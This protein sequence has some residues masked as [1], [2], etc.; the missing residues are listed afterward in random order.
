MPP[1]RINGLTKGQGHTLLLRWADG[2]IMEVPAND[3]LQGVDLHKHIYRAAT[4]FTQQ[5]DTPH[6]LAV[7]FDARIKSVQEYQRGWQHI[8]FDHNRVENS[9]SSA[10]YSYVSDRGAEQRIAAPALLPWMD[11]LLSPWYDCVPRHASRT[12]AGLI[13]QLPLIFAL[14]AFSAPPKSLRVLLSS[15]QPGKWMH[16]NLP[17]GRK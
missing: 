2:R 3:P 16:H 10:Y 12:Q 17:T 5:P 1:N 15:I 4:I 8:T 11:Q 6:L 13:G 14:A 9:D 7:P